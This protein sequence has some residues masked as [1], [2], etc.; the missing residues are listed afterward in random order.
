MTEPL[1]WLI[2]IYRVPAEPSKL[3]SAIWRRLKGLGALY[4]QN[5]VAALPASY[6]SERALRALRK[7]VL[8]MGGTAYLLSS[9]VVAGGG[10]VVAAFNATRDDEYE[11][12]IDKCN[13]FQ[14][15]VDKE[16]AA[17]HFTYA[18]LEENEED[19]VKLQKW[20]QKVAA[21]D[22]LGAA[23]RDDAQA[24]LDECAQTLETFA[25]RV[26]AEEEGA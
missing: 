12:I 16:F 3:R 8:E 11:E 6:A 18:E 2:L 26:F 17:S 5:S 23:K 9:K 7:E 19:L 20:F 21:R 22:V 25:V 10:D 4:L 13:D 14:A 1:D 15:Q 24:R